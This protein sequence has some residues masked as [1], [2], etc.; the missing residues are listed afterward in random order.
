[1]SNTGAWN[2]YIGYVCLRLKIVSSSLPRNLPCW[3]KNPQPDHPQVQRPQSQMQKPL[4]PGVPSS[5]F[6]VT[7]QKPYCKLHN[8]AIS[9][10]V[11][12]IWMTFPL[13]S[14]NW[15]TIKLLHYDM[16]RKRKEG[17]T[18]W[19]SRR[20]HFAPFVLLDEWADGQQ[21]HQFTLGA[22]ARHSQAA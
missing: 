10:L 8:D 15:V 17:V 22:M 18:G 7:I 3:R 2:Y 19:N 4:K 16:R 13:L 14:L 12:K 21:C 11:L 5:R 9:W 6:P 20:Q 1:M